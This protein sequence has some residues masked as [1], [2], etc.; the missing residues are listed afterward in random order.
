MHASFFKHYFNDVEKITFSYDDLELAYKRLASIMKGE[1]SISTLPTDIFTKVFR[2]E[3]AII[4]EANNAYITNRVAIAYAKAI[5]ESLDEKEA[6][7]FCKLFNMV[8]E[9]KQGIYYVDLKSYVNNMPSSQD[10]KLFY[11]HV[12]DGFVQL[13]EKKFFRFLQEAIRA[14]LSLIYEQERDERAKE[15]AEQLKEFIPKPKVKFNFEKPPCIESILTQLYAHENLSHYSRWV[16]AVYLI[17]TGMQTDEIK[18]LYENLPDY[19]EKITTY[20]LEHIKRRQ[21]KMP[22]CEK[23]LMYGLRKEECPC[24]KGLIDNPLA[25]KKKKD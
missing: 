6:M 8:V 18:K 19:N 14:K 15:F 17:N 1:K 25:Y 21:Y 16:L 3:R 7:E 20:Q 11:L 9:K 5:Y 24:N 12:S 4:K 13:D 2:A 22:S 23:M 10:Y